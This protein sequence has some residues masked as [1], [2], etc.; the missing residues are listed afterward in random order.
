MIVLVHMPYAAVQ[1]PS[2]ALGLLQAECNQHGLP[3]RVLYPNLQWLQVLGSSD[4]HAISTTVTEDLVGE[5]TFARAAFGDEAPPPEP[6][7]QFVCQRGN[8]ASHADPGAMLRRARDLSEAFIE[9][10]A[11]EVLSHRPRV[12]GAS[13]T[14]QQHCASLALLKRIKQLDPSVATV[15]GGAN[16]EGEMGVTLVRHFGWVDFVVSGEADQLVGPF[17]ASLLE[18]KPQPPYG[19][20]SREPASWSSGPEGQPPRATFLA[21]DRVARPDYDDYFRALQASGLDMLPG[22]LMETS[23]GCW[24]GEKHHCT[25]CGLN[26]SGMGYRSKSGQRVLEE[27]EHLSNRYGLSG[28]EVVDNILD[29]SHLKTI[30]PVLASRPKPFDLFYETKSNLKREQVELLA[31]A[32]VLWIQPGIE[33]MHDEILRLMDKGST[34]LTNVQLLQHAREFGVRVI[35]NFLV[36]F[37]GEKDEWYQEM[38]QWLPLI[39]HLQP[40]NGVAPVRYDRFSPYHSQPERYGIEYRAARTYRGV[41]PLAAEELEKLAYFFEDRTDQELPVS[42]RL[43]SPGRQALRALLKEWWEQFWSPLPPILS[44]S[45]TADGLLILDTRTVATARRHLLQG[46]RRQLLLECRTPRRFAEED[47]DLSWLVEQKLVLQLGQ[48]FLSLPVAG[49]LPRL[50]A[51]WRFP[52]GFP[53]RPEGLPIYRFPALESQFQPTK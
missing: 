33:S 23:R 49:N 9:R 25:F 43:Q 10:T 7:L 11:Q 53:E 3:S 50:P 29:H 35:W 15:M 38:V 5:W 1:H 16:C 31:S 51:P 47:S 40:A 2:L 30:M 19:V 37:P 48:R 39:Q 12:V 34:A 42:R 18:G 21:M 24:W 41:Y 32:G 45:E 13:S 36:C 8:L 14:F 46:R 17:F 28:F 6:F 52:G 44:M 20:I 22:L 26:G 4:Y 27:M